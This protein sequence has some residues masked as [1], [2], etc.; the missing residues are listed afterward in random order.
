MVKETRTR[1]MIKKPEKKKGKLRFDKGYN[2]CWD[3][4]EKWFQEFIVSIM[5]ELKS[6]AGNKKDK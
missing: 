6:I 2:K 1:R 4:R 3:E 5:D